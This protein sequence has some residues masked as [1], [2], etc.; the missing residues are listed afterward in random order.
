MLANPALQGFLMFL[1]GT[2][3]TLGDVHNRIGAWVCWAVAA[4]L[5]VVA[6]LRWTRW[7][8]SYG[9]KMESVWYL[10][11][12]GRVSLRKAAEII[13]SEARAQDSIW[14]HAAERMSLDKSPDGVLCYIAEVIKQDTPIYGKRRPSTHMEQ[15]DPLQ[16]KYGNVKNGALEIHMRDDTKAVFTDLE[17]DAKELRRALV[18]VRDSL[19]TT[20]PI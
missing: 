3:L 6:F 5:L 7:P 20:M 12:G 14:A 8:G 10:R 4:L 18:E 19:R 1:V 9:R 2:A 13:Y 16:L 15:L 11:W 17:V